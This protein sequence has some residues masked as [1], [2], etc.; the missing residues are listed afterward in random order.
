M[1]KS[2]CIENDR[3][4]AAPVPNFMYLATKVL[5]WAWFWR[6]SQ[7]QSVLSGGFD[8]TIAH[9]PSCA[10]QPWEFLPPGPIRGLDYPGVACLSAHTGRWKVA[11]P[12][13]KDTARV[14]EGDTRDGE[15]VES[16]DKQWQ[17]GDLRYIQTPDGMNM[18]R[19]CRN[20]QNK[21]T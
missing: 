18:K 9:L 1:V 14:R 8:I 20:R 4:T 3:L 16:K 12:L 21:S 17:S 5:N 15:G 19:K 6:G 10:I 11:E 13:Q 2:H 7:V